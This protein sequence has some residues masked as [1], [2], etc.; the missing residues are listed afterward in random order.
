MPIELRSARSDELDQLGQLTSYVYGGN[1]GDGPENT[2][3]ATTR[4]EWTLCAFD[5]PRLVSSFSTIPFT[6]RANGT[7]VPM[8]GVSAVGTLPEYRR[9]GLV[10]RIATRAFADMR[11]RGQAVASL[12]ASQA[13]I[14][15][16]YGYAM[17]SVLR[18]YRVDTADIAFHDGDDGTSRVERLDVSSGYDLVKQVYIAFIADRMCYLHRARP[19]WL[20]NALDEGDAE[21]PIHIALARGADGQPDGYAIYTLRAGKRDHASRGQEVVIRDLAWLSPGAYRS[22]WSFIGRHDLV[23]SV[24]WDNAPADDPAVEFFME[25]R[26]LHARDHEGF[27]LRV[28]D[29]PEAL[30]GRGWDADGE[31]TIAVAEDSLAPWNTGTWRVSVSGGS[32]EVASGNG[33]ADLRLSVKA[34]ALL[35]TGRRS[36]RELRAWGMLEGEPGALRRADALFATP[37]AP[38]CPDHF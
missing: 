2:I 24:R 27:W 19:L 35:Y 12:W 21:G 6:M 1:H 8:G 15:Q 5:G 9:Q 25:P 17:A 23:G 3:T 26:L 18:S 13:A 33:S 14:Y 29:V 32:A 20:N 11:E 7:A 22:L 16:R 36:A 28:V 31:L 34:L 10:R 30:A 37:H 4:P 38:H